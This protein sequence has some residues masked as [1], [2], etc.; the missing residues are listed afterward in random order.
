MLFFTVKM[1]DFENRVDAAQSHAAMEETIR[2]ALWRMDSAAAL[3]LATKSGNTPN[4]N[5][6]FS[7][8]EVQVTG[9]NVPV[10][11]QNAQRI[12]PAYQ[13]AISAQEFGQR[14]ALASDT[15][16]TGIPSNT[17]CLRRFKTYF[18]MRRWKK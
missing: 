11:T 9:S 5:E 15:L 10:Q 4:P 1:L 13:Q 17:P 18:Q 12:D 6:T 7:L 8:P 3:L 14:I 16:M 2:L